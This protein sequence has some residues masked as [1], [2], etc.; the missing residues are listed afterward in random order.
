MTKPESPCIL[1]VDDDEHICRT[2]SVIL[3]KEGYQTAMALTAKEAL[4]KAQ[5]RFFD[6]AL[7]DIRLPDMQGTQLLKQLQEVSPETI[8]IMVTG[9]PSLKNAVDALNFGADSYVMKPVDPADLLETIK[10]KLEVRKKTEQI[11]K[12]KL[13]AWIQSQALKAKSPSF[14]EFLNKAVAELAVFGLTKTQAKIYLTLIALGVASASEIAGT[15]KVRREEVYRIIPELEKRGMIT[16]KLET[17][18]KFLAVKPETAIKVL[19]KDKMKTMKDEIENLQKKETELVSKLKAIELPIKHEN[20]SIEVI[21]QSDIVF[22]KLTEMIKHARSKIDAV[23]PLSNFKLVYINRS[24]KL[25]ENV[26]KTVKIRMVTQKCELD[27]FTKEILK[28]SAES[29]NPIE[30]RQLEKLPFDIFIVDDREAVWGDHDSDGKALTFWTDKPTQ[31]GILK[32]SFEGLW[33][34][35][36]VTDKIE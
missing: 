11:T 23:A 15:S 28:F 2:L 6:M 9:Y 18:R 32:E 36:F 10:D 3:E 5:T 29:N 13:A 21:S 8:K 31:I 30:F 14:Q 20:S 16:K 12:E 34:K 24:R 19:T 35:A 7:L 22:T 33:Q 25:M 1:I 4:E 26:L 17:P 27:D